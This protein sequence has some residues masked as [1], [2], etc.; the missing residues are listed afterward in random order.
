MLADTPL[1]PERCHFGRKI[2][3]FPEKGKLMNHDTRTQG[4]VI[5]GLSLATLVL[6]TAWNTREPARAE[7]GAALHDIIVVVGNHANNEKLYIVH[8]VR[9]VLAVYEARPNNDLRL[10]SGRDLDKD[11]DF[12]KAARD[13]KYK[14]QGYSVSEIEK[15]MMSK[16]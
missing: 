15:A 7:G 16:P 6:F 3:A 1:P 12:I 13:L 2:E 11:F 5:F 10:V 9:K 4:W 14:D 8:P